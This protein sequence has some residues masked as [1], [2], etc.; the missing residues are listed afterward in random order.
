MFVLAGIAWSVVDGY[1]R[2]RF[3]Q[4]GTCRRATFYNAVKESIRRVPYQKRSFQQSKLNRKNGFK[5][6]TEI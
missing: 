1:R 3:F 4:E 5:V 6:V 2:H